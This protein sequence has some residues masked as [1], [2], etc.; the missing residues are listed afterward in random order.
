M[1][2][3]WNLISVNL[4][5]VST[6]SGHI[7]LHPGGPF[8]KYCKNVADSLNNCTDRSAIFTLIYDH[9]IDKLYLSDS[10]FE[11]KFISN[12]VEYKA[13]W[14]GCRSE[15]SL[16]RNKRV[17]LGT[18][19]H[20]HQLS[21]IYLL[22]INCIFTSNINHAM[23]NLR[24]IFST[25]FHV[26]FQK[27]KQFRICLEEYVTKGCKR[28]KTGIWCS[29]VC[30]EITRVSQLWIFIYVSKFVCLFAFFYFQL[31]FI[32]YHLQLICIQNF[33]SLL[34]FEHWTIKRPFIISFF[35]F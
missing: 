5:S 17:F 9:T 27:F 16:F 6:C 24:N 14:K 2:N 8:F 7:M 13:S 1:L 12:I 26:L 34:L 35:F 20:N 29:S 33:K 25:I 22:N 30:A 31:T 4:V 21:A 10:D 15:L 18:T 11:R 32:K 28:R 19:T 3:E 23:Y